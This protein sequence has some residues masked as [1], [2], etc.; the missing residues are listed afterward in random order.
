MKV[1]V[2]VSNR[3]V[4]LNQEDLEVLFGKD[5]QLNNISNLNQPG[6]F[7]TDWVV[8]IKTEKSENGMLK[9]Q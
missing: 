5:Y 2:G 4:H 3:H 8:T 7:K 1:S 6:Q 9:N